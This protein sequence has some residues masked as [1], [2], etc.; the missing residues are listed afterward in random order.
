MFARLLMPVDPNNLPE[1]YDILLSA[2]TLNIALPLAYISK[3]K[4]KP[5]PDALGWNDRWALCSTAQQLDIA[6]VAKELGP[7]TG[8]GTVTP[9]KNAAPA[10]PKLPSASPEPESKVHVSETPGTPILMA[11]SKPKAGSKLK[12]GDDAA[13]DKDEDDDHKTKRLKRSNRSTSKAQAAGSK[14]RAVS[15]PR[16]TQS[17]V[18]DEGPVSDESNG[19]GSK[20]ASMTTA[21]KVASVL[22]LFGYSQRPSWHHLVR[23]WF[24]SILRVQTVFLML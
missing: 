4:K 22:Y 5:L 9:F 11:A 14:R 17:D 24:K 12:R 2:N 15:D 16:L 3:Y 1:H 18:D 19:E 20:W 10:P 13:T 7:K 8:F 6:A 23:T 21:D